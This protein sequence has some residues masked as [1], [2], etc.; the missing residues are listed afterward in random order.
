MK[1]VFMNS[2]GNYYVATV[3]SDG[4]HHQPA[5]FI[6][7]NCWETEAEATESLRKTRSVRC[8]SDSIGCPYCDGRTL[9][10]DTQPRWNGEKGDY[11]HYFHRAS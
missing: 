5:L 2:D 10:W 6:G 7:I 3:L 8:A 11:F 9:G 1:E 4:S